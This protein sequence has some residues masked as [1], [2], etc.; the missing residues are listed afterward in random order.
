M[1]EMQFGDMLVTQLARVHESGNEAW[2]IVRSDLVRRLGKRLLLAGTE[3]NDVRRLA[4]QVIEH[5]EEVRAAILEYYEADKPA[6]AAF[7]EFF[8]AIREAGRTLVAA[9]DSRPRPPGKSPE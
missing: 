9:L 8:Q 4:R 5:P 1:T 6:A 2:R 3:D 7:A